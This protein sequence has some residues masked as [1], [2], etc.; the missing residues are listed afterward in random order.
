MLT[1]EPFPRKAA[2]LLRVLLFTLAA[3]CIWGSGSSSPARAEGWHL[4]F[5][6][7]FTGTS[8]DLDR[9]ATRYI[10]QH[11]TLASLGSEA[12]RYADN[13]NHVVAG[14]N[15]SL[16]ARSV[17]KLSIQSKFESGMIRSRQT[18]YYGYFE[19]RIFLPSA[20]GVFPAFWL[21]PDYD[22]DGDL[23]WPPEIDAFEFVIDGWDSRP[24]MLHSSVVTKGFKDPRQGA[25]LYSAPQ[26]NREFS[27]FRG[28]KPFNTGWQVI[29]LLWKPD[30]VTAYLNGVKLWTRSYRWITN[31]GNL[32]AP[33][34]ILLNLGVG[35]D[36]AGRN[37]IANAEFPQK[38]MIDYVKVCQFSAG[39]DG[40]RFCA[41]SAYTPSFD[42][43]RYDSIDDMPK[44]RLVSATLSQ[45]V[46][47]PGDFIRLRLAIDAVATPR[48]RS[49]AVT[50][51][52]SRGQTA[53][54]KLLSPT[55]PTT[56][57]HGSY[58]NR[59]SIRLP[60]KLKPGCYS[61]FFSLGSMNQQ[62]Q[63]INSPIT[64]SSAFGR[65][66]EYL[67]FRIGDIAVSDN[68]PSK[69]TTCSD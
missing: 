37:G 46:A 31:S 42:E 17:S 35:G 54:I 45:T 40:E 28:S 6:D 26:F 11:G 13:A 21:N 60:A 27:Y 56:K 64:A 43:S 3:I 8:L 52:D 22:A 12:E 34:H 5:F 24:D 59:W 39:K 2:G 55:V 29:G 53:L 7:D 1:F 61:T 50:L 14:G 9:W 48:E 36:W 65:R 18:F 57:W 62:G 30:T 15:L 16:I 19:A 23:H 63:W 67:R 41:G 44:T 20:R 68:R 51:I 47:R 33:A 69:R 38:L 49:L 58:E 25:W 32:A 4:V 10:Y 66:D